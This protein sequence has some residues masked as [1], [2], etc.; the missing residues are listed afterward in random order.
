[1]RL[2][3]IRSDEAVYINYVCYTPLSMQSVPPT[4]HA[5][6]WLDASGF[7]EFNDGSQNEEIVELPTWAFECVE[8]WE[9]ANYAHNNPPPPPT[10][11]DNKLTAI[12]LLSETDWTALPDV[13]N[14][15]KSNPYLGNAN[16]FNVYRNELR[17]IAINPMAGVLIWPV[18][19]QEEW[20]NS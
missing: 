18:L 19:P 16:E 8:E 14:P 9:A 15:L 2:T 1:M 20:L 12:S 3:I 4:V 11:E 10:A 7:I 13:S 5:L 17:K 6:Q